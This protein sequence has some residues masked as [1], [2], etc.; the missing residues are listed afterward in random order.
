MTVGFPDYARLSQ[1]G[2]YLL[3]GNSGNI[4]QNQILFEGYVGTWPYVNMATNFGAS[5]D[6]AQMNLV[7]F[8]D[9][10]FNDVIGFRYAIRAG[11]SFAMTQ[12]ANLTPWLRFYYE[13]KSGLAMPFTNLAL[14]ASQGI[15]NQWQLASMD[16]PILS[17]D[18]SIGANTTA[19]VDI[20]HIQPGPGNINMFT[21]A[22]SWFININRYDWGSAGYVFDSTVNSAKYGQALSVD[23]P[24]ID[25]PYQFQ[26]HNGDSVAQ[27][28]EMSWKSN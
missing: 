18:Q 24:M 20:N 12:Y 22:A 19:T 25:A 15:A 9:E 3:Y 17:L 27:T 2:G 4:N 14:Y 8:A 7:Y 21:G 16:V 10:T 26:I 23:L 1:Q 13:S 5:T 11:A 6:F 28:F